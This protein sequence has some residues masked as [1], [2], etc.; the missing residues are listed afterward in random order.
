TFTPSQATPNAQIYFGVGATAAVVELA[1]IGLFAPPSASTPTPTA[2]N[3]ASPTPIPPTS[4]PAPPTSTPTPTGTPGPNSVV[5]GSFETGSVS[6]WS[7]TIDSGSGVAGPPT[8]DTS[9]AADGSDSAKI[10]VTTAS[11]QDYQI[12]LLQN[13]LPLTGGQST[14]LV[15]WAKAS[16]VHS[17]RVVLKSNTSATYLEYVNASVQVLTGWN[18]YAI[19]F[20][21]SQS[22]SNV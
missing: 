8:V 17:I 10:V 20:T 5:N 21:P 3:S 4:T 1:Q 12:R 6:P 14:T 22:D 15:F 2:T 19:T 11:Q 13:N 9:T 18:R 16:V 7:L